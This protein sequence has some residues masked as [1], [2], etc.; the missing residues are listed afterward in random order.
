MNMRWN[1]FLIAQYTEE[2]I[3]AGELTFPKSQFSFYQRISPSRFFQQV[4]IDGN[5]G[6]DVDFQN[7]RAGRGGSFD[8]YASL[9]ATNHLVFEVI[10]NA[11]WLNVDDATG[12]NRR[13]FTAHVQRVRA[14]YTFTA[15]SFVRLIGQYVSTDRDPSL[16]IQPIAAH[17]GTFNG[18]VLLAYKINWQSV[19]FVGYGDDRE[20]TDLRRL[21]PSGHQVFVKISYAFQ[22]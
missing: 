16:F 7:V 14:N 15:R 4:G 20:L 5:F 17:D 18:S 12:T 8:V 22:K 2:R 21:Q 13:L 10:D 6:S 19:M 1:G 11:T 3:R 9:N